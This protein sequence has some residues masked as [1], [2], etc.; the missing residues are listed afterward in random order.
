M[1]RSFVIAMMFL[2]TATGSWAAGPV[3]RWDRIEGVLAA[4]LMEIHVGD[5]PA[6]GRWRT[7]GE[8]GA[9]LNLRTGFLSFRVEGISWANHYPN[10]PLGAPATGAVMGTVVCDSTD[11]WM[12]TVDTEPVPMDEGSG[13]FVGIIDLPESCRARPEGIVFLLRHA[14]P[15]PLFGNFVAYGAGRS[16]QRDSAYRPIDDELPFWPDRPVRN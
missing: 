2:V 1:R 12:V 3:V 5:I 16:I 6:S 13:S 10:G 14:A 8:G 15:G 4:N 7:A 9:M 11:P